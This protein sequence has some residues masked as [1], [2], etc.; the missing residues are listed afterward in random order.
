MLFISHLSVRFEEENPP[1]KTR[2][3]PTSGLK[4]PSKA[5]KQKLVPKTEV[6]VINPLTT[7]EFKSLPK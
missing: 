5:K 1:V 7:Q 4:R 2:P 3:V 6:P